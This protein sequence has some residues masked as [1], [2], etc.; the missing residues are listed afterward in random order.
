MNWMR[1][2]VPCTVLAIDLASTVLPVPGTSSSRR[3]PPVSMQVSAS[4][5]VLVLPLM[6]MSTLSTSWSKVSANHAD[7]SGWMV[8]GSSQCLCAGV[9]GC[10]SQSPVGVTW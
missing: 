1:E 7:W 2:L 6:A 8:M 4:R 10:A 9:W 3:W 5:I